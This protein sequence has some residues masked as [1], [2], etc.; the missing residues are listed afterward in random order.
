MTGLERGECAADAV[1][2][3]IAS[4]AWRRLG[5]W[6]GGIGGSGPLWVPGWTGA[7]TSTVP[8]HPGRWVIE[9]A[10]RLAR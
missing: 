1:I 10:P 6:V 7:G 2:E 3:S 5:A 9:A 8:S 4:A